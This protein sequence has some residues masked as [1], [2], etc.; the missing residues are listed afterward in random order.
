VDA[1][2]QL[3]RELPIAKQ[4]ASVNLL[5]AQQR[6]E[7]V[8]ADRDYAAR[9]LAAALGY[10]ANDLVQPAPEERSALTIPATEEAAVRAAY[11]SSKDLRLL[12]SRYAAKGLEIKGD[13]A[14]RLPRVDLIAQYALLSQYSNYSQYFLRFQRND[15]EIGASIQIPIVVGPGVK[16][17]V[18]QAETDQLHIR[19]EEQVLRNRI[20][21][22]IHHEFQDL[23][24]A[25]RTNAMA[26]AELDLARAQLS[27]L[28]AQFQEGR[29]SLSQVEDAR[30]TED[31]KWAA[32]YDAQYGEEKARLNLLNRTGGLMTALQ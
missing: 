16:A 26:K 6:L 19:S 31:E 30:F 12:E 13:K 25:N 28:L 18:S 11:E 5:R 21:L 32:F 29:A 7:D 8:R 10:T 2:V 15:A 17:Q 3:G 23:E 20:A 24:K 27:V 14:Q 9:S 22:D 4:Q 1:R